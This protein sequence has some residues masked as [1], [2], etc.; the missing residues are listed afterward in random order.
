MNLFL[1][2]CWWFPFTI[3]GFSNTKRINIINK[4]I[5]FHFALL[6]TILRSY[7]TMKWKWQYIVYVVGVIDFVVSEICVI[8][9]N[10]IESIYFGTSD[11]WH[12]SQNNQYIGV[13]S[14]FVLSQFIRYALFQL[15]KFVAAVISWFF[16][17]SFVQWSSNGVWKEIKKIC[18]VP[19]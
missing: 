2:E 7:G 14:V 8:E 15:L 3:N 4:S 12:S 9:S 6:C 10:W 13:F 16:Q 5:G 11:A 19:L 1:F 18:L 17:N